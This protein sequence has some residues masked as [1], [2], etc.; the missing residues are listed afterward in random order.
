MEFYPPIWC[1][2]CSLDFNLWKSGIVIGIPFVGCC[3]CSLCFIR[4]CS[5]QW[6]S[7]DEVYIKA[8]PINVFVSQMVFYMIWSTKFDGVIGSIR[9]TSIVEMNSVWHTFKVRS[10]KWCVQKI[11]S[12]FCGS[13]N[14]SQI[15]ESDM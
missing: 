5:I 3:W 10:K 9:N 2:F 15:I 6:W 13:A 4:E 1:I 8:T 14:E 11:C 7:H 12:T